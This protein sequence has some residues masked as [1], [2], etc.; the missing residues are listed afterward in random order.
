MLF[1]YNTLIN[2]TWPQ[3]MTHYILQP[4][5]D[6]LLPHHKDMIHY[7]PTTRGWQ[8]MSPTRGWHTMNISSSAGLVSIA[9]SFF[10]LKI[11]NIDIH[12]NVLN[13]RSTSQT[14]LNWKTCLTICKF[15]GWFYQSMTPY[16]AHLVV[17]HEPSLMTLCMQLPGHIED[18]Q[19]VTL[20][21]LCKWMSEG[22]SDIIKRQTLLRTMKKGS[23]R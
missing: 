7:A 4:G 12:G 18:K 20:T 15:I 16:P 8:T 13:W 11:I 17:M 19:W 10:R 9:F 5:D 14:C 2:W 6:T 23:C 1:S 21:M 3:G 22:G